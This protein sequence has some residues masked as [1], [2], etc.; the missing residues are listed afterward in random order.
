VR[1]GVRG[2]ETTYV[3]TLINFQLNLQPTYTPHKLRKRFDLQAFT[4]GKNYKD[5][6]V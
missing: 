6:F 4:T 1:T 2:E 5:G 3:P